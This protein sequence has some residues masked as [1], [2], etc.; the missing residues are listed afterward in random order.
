MDVILINGQEISG[1]VRRRF[2][3]TNWDGREACE[4]TMEL[5]HAEAAALFVTNATWGYRRT[6]TDMTGT[7]DIETDMSDY[8]VAGP[9]TDLRDGR[10]RVLMG[11]I[12]A[13]EALAELMEALQT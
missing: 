13:E 1:R 4:L 6:V 9:I 11:K 10:L 7:T 5:S 12:T 2:A 3:C 8:S